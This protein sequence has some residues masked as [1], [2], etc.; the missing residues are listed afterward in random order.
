MTSVF[1]QVRLD[2]TRLPRKALALLGDRT[3][4][5]RCFQALDAVESDRKVLVTEPS[6]ADELKPLADKSGWDL[7]VGSKDDVLDRFVQAARATGTTTIVRATGDN[8]LV[9]ADLANRLLRLHR[10][11]HADYSGFL[12]GPVGSGV[13]ILAVEALERAWSSAPDAYEREHVSPYLYRRTEEFR[14]LRP[15]VEASCRCPEGR[16][17]LDTP[18]DLEVLRKLWAGIYRGRPPILEEVIAWLKQHPR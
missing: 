2:S 8:P 10:S 18:E 16:I 13:E 14:I 17:T 1:L 7:L 4:T 12:G 5:E 6:S 15:Q 3:V 11:E 9:S